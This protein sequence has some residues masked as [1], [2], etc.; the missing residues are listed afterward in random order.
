MVFFWTMDL[1]VCATITLL[2][3]SCLF[4]VEVVQKL[5]FTTL[6]ETLLYNSPGDSS[7]FDP[8]LDAYAYYITD[9]SS[10]EPGKNFSTTTQPT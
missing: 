2:D 8:I 4:V 6:P 9:K 5:I 10:A 7:S 1:L 3:K